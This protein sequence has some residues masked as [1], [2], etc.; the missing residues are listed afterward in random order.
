MRDA[1]AGKILWITGASSGIGEALALESVRQ[2]A[3]VILSARRVAELYRVKHAIISATLCDAARVA[4]I[5]LD[6]ADSLDIADK[7]AAA[8][9][10]FG[11]I[12]IVC[13]NA[14]ISQRATALE[15]EE[16]VD[17]RLMEVN[18]FGTIAITKALLPYF[19]KQGSG[20]IVVTSSIAG[21]VGTRKRTAY[22]ASKHALHGFFNGLR[23]E[24]SGQNIAVTLLC[25]GYINTPLPLAALTGDGNPQGKMDSQQLNGMPPEIFARKALRAIHRR[26]F[27]ALI[28]GKE[29]LAPLIFRFFPRLFARIAARH[30]PH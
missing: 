27:Q 12:D 3:Y 15:T 5:P 26:Q 20:Q 17:R 9:R 16:E 1:F 23:A 8:W 30:T 6:V 28:G 2:G 19:L 25:P 10:A 13:N 21:L 4:I 11:S 18:Y 22:C 24:L 14:G 7:T 29:T